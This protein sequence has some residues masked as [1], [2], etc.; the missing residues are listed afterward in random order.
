LP[1]VLLPQVLISFFLSPNQR[2][3]H[4]HSPFMHFSRPQTNIHVVNSICRL[5]CHFHLLGTRVPIINR[6]TFFIFAFTKYMS[7][8]DTR[9]WGLFVHYL[10]T[11]EWENAERTKGEKRGLH[12]RGNGETFYF[13]FFPVHGLHGSP[14]HRAFLS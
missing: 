12:L 11:L 6:I 4:T 2:W 10:A 9:V 14:Y 13:A 8:S 3:V 7:A 1:C 5:G